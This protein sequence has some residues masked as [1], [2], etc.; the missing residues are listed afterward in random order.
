[1]KWKGSREHE[2]HFKG[3]SK[4]VCRKQRSDLSHGIPSVEEG[5]KFSAKHVW[6]LQPVNA[7]SD[8]LELKFAIRNAITCVE[9]A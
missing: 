3:L 2:N 7:I 1:M 6:Q 9:A 5:T 4:A 8:L